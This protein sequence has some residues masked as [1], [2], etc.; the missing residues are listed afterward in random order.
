MNSF[1]KNSLPDR[2]EK[3]PCGSVI[4]HGPYNERIY[5]LKVGG[6]ATGLLP[7]VLVA[8]A[9]GYG[10]SK[11]FVK[12]PTGFSKKFSR[13]GYVEEA[14][15][16]GLYNGSN[17][18]TFMGYYLKEQ[19]ASEREAAT[20]DAI[21]HLAISRS[22]SPV[23]PL[24]AKRFIIRSC[25]ES[26]IDQMAAIYRTVFPTYPFPIHDPAYL[27]DTMR[28][29]V[30]YF[31][32]ESDGKL[33][34]LSSAEMDKSAQNVEMTDFATLLQWQRS[35]LS[36][37]LLARMEKEMKQE[38]IKTAYTIARAMSPG[39]NVTFSRLGYAYGGR[40]KNNTN[41]SA[42]IESMNVWYKKLS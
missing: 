31:G 20:L 8:M 30:A 40:L 14:S 12:V 38:G 25:T 35:S 11:I 37:H 36:L 4:Q 32:V 7:F 16:P 21:L 3:L 42:Q 1:V 29:H 10:Y 22:E 2:I 39:I 23:T 17:T 26:D 24:D 15:I 5:L 6:D 9:K 41:I 27:L 34:A 19:R 18:G 28:S 13:A 33:V